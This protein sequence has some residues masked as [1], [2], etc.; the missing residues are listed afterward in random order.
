LKK[1]QGIIILVTAALSVLVIYASKLVGPVRDIQIPSNVTIMI[2]TGGMAAAIRLY[3]FVE[4]TPSFAASAVFNTSAEMMLLIEPDGSI[5]K[6][7]R[8]FISKMGGRESDVENIRLSLILEG[9]EE[10]YGRILKRAMEGNTASME[11]RIKI[12]PDWM[13]CL[14]EVSLLKRNGVTAGIVAVLTDISELNNAQNELKKYR[15][16]L[17]TMVK[18]R[19]TELDRANIKLRYKAETAMEF[20]KASHHDLREP[21]IGI[22]NLLQRLLLRKKEQL[23]DEANKDIEDAVGYAKRLNDLIRDMR[24]YINVDY[25]AGE[26]V[27]GNPAKALMEA[28][29]E[30]EKKAVIISRDLSD[31]YC[32]Q[33]LLKDIFKRLLDNSVRFSGKTNVNIWVSSELKDGKTEFTFE[34]DGIGVD[35]AYLKK[36]FGVF[37]R[38]LERVNYPGNGMGLAIC[39]KT[40]ELHGGRIWAE[41]SVK[42]GLAVKFTLKTRLG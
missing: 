41:R 10:A 36:I 38:L 14:I 21:V 22:V 28:S 11:M 40:V 8:A 13:H 23:D 25:L 37:E 19:T 20:T 17:E 32:P 34:D 24:D 39:R 9:G 12:G 31:V 42:G 4:L 16:N 3:G 2:V 1:R 35:E 27:A 5:A 29:K 33:E 26:N 15:D 18:D 7:N 6:A 30:F